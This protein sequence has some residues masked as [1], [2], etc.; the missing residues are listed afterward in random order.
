LFISSFFY[1]SGAVLFLLSFAF[2]GVFVGLAA[3]SSGKEIS[4]SFLNDHRKSFFSI[5]VLIFIVILS[6]AVTFKYI[7]RFASVSYFGQA[8]SASTEPIAENYINKAL[9]L[10]T[11]DLYLRTY[12]QIYL[13]KSN[14]IANKG[15]AL[16][17]ADQTNLKNSFSQ[18]IGYA[19]LA[20]TYDPQNYLNFQLLGSVYQTVG[21][22]GVKDVYGSA[23]SAYQT[24]S[25]LNPLN[26][27]LKLSMSG[28]SFVNGDTPGAKN[29][30]N[31][32]LSLKPDYVDALVTLSQIA[33]SEGNTSSALSYAESALSLTPTNDPSYKNLSQ[34]VDSLN[35]SSPAS[36]VPA[37]T[38][39]TSSTPSSKSKK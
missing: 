23:L 27:G 16:S 12:S 10:Y 15:A 28:V 8:V 4:M 6:V 36:S 26:P 1:F 14:S 24:A 32:A 38:P 2:T 11:N 13:V 25:A 29:Y 19:Q 33:K 17:D 7:E 3:S 37:T 21:G 30:A 22:L 20:T 9:S 31:Q 39:T 34:Y 35:G 18:A 5:L